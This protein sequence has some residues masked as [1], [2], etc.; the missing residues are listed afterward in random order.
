MNIQ[1]DPQSLDLLLQAYRATTY[2]VLLRAA[3]H[4]EQIIPVRVGTAPAWPAKLMDKNTK[5]H[6]ITAYNPGSTRFGLKANQQ[7]QQHLAKLIEQAGLS[8]FSTIAVADAGD[9][10][11]EPGLLVLN[12]TGRQIQ[13]WCRQFEQLAV[14]GGSGHG[15]AWLQ[16]SQPGPPWP[17]HPWRQNI[18]S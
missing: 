12:A 10:P 3:P 9:W 2:H 1:P 8:T 16:F 11:A 4:A 6:I 13:A 17:E 5:W 7:R 14:I 15:P 18:I